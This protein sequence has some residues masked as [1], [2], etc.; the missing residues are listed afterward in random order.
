MKLKKWDYV[1]AAIVVVLFVACLVHVSI[2]YSFM[3]QNSSSGMLFPQP[4]P[5]PPDYFYYAY[6]PE[7]A[8]LLIIPYA[9]AELITVTIWLI[10]SRILRKKA[11]NQ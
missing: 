11:T 8:F 5:Y 2:V 4:Y 7:I 3:K 6:P 9:I 1:F 10:V